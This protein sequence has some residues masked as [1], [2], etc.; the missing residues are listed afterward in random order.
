MPLSLMLTWWNLIYI[1]PFLLAVAYLGLFVFT[2]ITFGDADADVEMDGDVD[3]GAA[4][5]VEAHAVD[6][7]AGGDAHFDHDVGDHD[8]QAAHASSDVLMPH[9]PHA[10]ATVDAGHELHPFM[11]FLSLMGVGKIP[12]SLALM[13]LFFS[14][15]LVGVGLNGLLIQWLGAS[16]VVGF[17]SVPITLIVSLVVTGLCAAGFAKVFP[18]NDSSRQRRQDLVGKSGE[19]IY[20]IDAAFGMAS[21]RGDA[22]DFFQIPCRTRDE[23]A[24]IPKGSRVVIFDYDR[25]K[26]IFHVAPLRE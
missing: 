1:V 25:D 23:S 2:G 6:I 17:I 26:G 18:N 8:A 16:F 7:G 9:A 20:D 24:R 21:V 19:A 13:I 4:L 22:G 14:W 5:H 3:A 11:A 10:H 12:L 15:G